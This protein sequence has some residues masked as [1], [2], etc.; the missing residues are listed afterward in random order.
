VLARLGGDEF[1]VILPH[2]DSE[3][4]RAVAAALVEGVRACGATVSIGV[5]SFDEADTFH[6]ADLAMYEAKGAG[7]DR[8]A[9]A[10]GA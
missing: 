8:W 1:A 3:A 4:A 7:G 6:R 9:S 2:T 5:A 10:A